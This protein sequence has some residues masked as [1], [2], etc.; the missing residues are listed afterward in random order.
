M[1]LVISDFGLSIADLFAG[2]LAHH[3]NFKGK[4]SMKIASLNFKFSIILLRCSA[5]LFFALP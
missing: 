3:Y 4:Q 2:G 5:L 1:G